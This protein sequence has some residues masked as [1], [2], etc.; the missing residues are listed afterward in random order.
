MKL[1]VFGATGGTGRHVV[2]QALQQGHEVSA[3]VRSDPQPGFGDARVRI[4]VGSVADDSTAVTRA[5]RGQ[6][7]VVCALGVR[8]TFKSSNLI[9]RS[10]RNIVPAMETQGVKRFVLVSA[11]GVGDS[12]AHAPLVPR[13]MYRLLLGDIFADKKAAEDY[14]RASG[15]DWTVLYP[16]LLTDGPRT[17]KYRSGERLELAGMPKISRADVAD[18]VLAQLASDAYLCRI[19]AISY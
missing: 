4:V 13:I 11:F 15:L 18:F 5:V 12:R 19:V 7:A 8:N 1:L 16:V 2:A 10:L 3:F 6:D 9:L 14:L 17:G